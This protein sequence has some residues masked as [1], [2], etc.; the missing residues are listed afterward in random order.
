[1]RVKLSEIASLRDLAT[2]NDW[3]RTLYLFSGTIIDSSTCQY[4]VGE[5]A[6]GAIA[7]DRICRVISVAETGNFIERRLD[8][9]RC[10]LGSPSA[11]A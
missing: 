10:L 1:M 6:I 11:G 9:A 5:A 8:V 7:P 2:P 4:D 3:Q